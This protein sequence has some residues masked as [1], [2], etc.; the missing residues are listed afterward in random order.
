MVLT[1]TLPT[2]YS[3]VLAVASSSFLLGTYHYILTAVARGKAKVPYPVAYASKE[4]ADKDPA[5]FKFNCA[6]RAQSNFVEN[7]SGWLGAL[8]ISGLRFPVASAGLGAVWVVARVLYGQGYTSKKGPKGRILGSSLASLTDLSL[9]V[10]AVY[11]TVS[12]VLA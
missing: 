12:M 10:M 7:H 1:I 2:E 6:Q 8:L 3:Y 5:V 11:T 9:R 4:E